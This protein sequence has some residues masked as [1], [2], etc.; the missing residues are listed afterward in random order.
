MKLVFELNNA[1]FQ[2]AY[3]QKQWIDYNHAD[4]LNRNIYSENRITAAL[5][6]T[7]FILG[8]G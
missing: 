3:F 6:V 2:R 8:C 4:E 1:I 5:R 7:I